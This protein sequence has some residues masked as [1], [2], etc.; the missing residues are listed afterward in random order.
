MGPILK[1]IMFCLALKDASSSIKKY[2][3]DSVT[4][5]STKGIKMEILSNGNLKLEDLTAKSKMVMVVVSTKWC[6]P[7]HQ[8]APILDELEKEVPDVKFFKVDVSEE[9]PPF[10]GAMGIRSVPTI[11]FYKDNV[12]KNSIN[13]ARTKVELSKE[14][15]SLIKS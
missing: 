14:L 9:V 4:G 11:L 15:T 5:K 7:C 1:A 8:M 6:A 12:M 13:G 10:I 3:V 2:S